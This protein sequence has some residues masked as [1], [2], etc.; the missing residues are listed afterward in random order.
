MRAAPLETLIEL[1]EL[2]RSASGACPMCRGTMRPWRAAGLKPSVDHITPRAWNGGNSLENLRL[3]CAD[4]NSQRGSVDHCLGALACVLSIAKPSGVG[5]VWARWR[6]N[7]LPPPIPKPKPIAPA[8]P[9]KPFIPLNAA[10][11]W[12]VSPFDTYGGKRARQLTARLIK[13]GNI[14]AM[15]AGVRSV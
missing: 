11:F 2:R 8:P 1:A 6:G 3:M 14:V 7:A 5:R 4:C 9:P 15:R 13:I 10:I 12:P